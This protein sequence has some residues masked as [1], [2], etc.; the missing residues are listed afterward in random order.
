MS[1]IVFCCTGSCSVIN[2]QRS[3]IDNMSVSKADLKLDVMTDNRHK[4]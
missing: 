4:D 3:G 1:S 2:T